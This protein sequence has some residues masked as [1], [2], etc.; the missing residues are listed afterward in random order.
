MSTQ[1][2]K[3]DPEQG[4]VSG[5]TENPLRASLLSRKTQVRESVRTGASHTFQV[6]VTGLES[7]RTPGSHRFYEGSE[8]PFSHFLQS[9]LLL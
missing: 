8:E 5:P 7:R 1:K 2:K 6:P 3:K 4:Q 9:V